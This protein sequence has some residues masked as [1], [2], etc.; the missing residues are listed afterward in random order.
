MQLARGA[1]GIS[2]SDLASDIGVSQPAVSMWEKGDRVP[3]DAALERLAAALQVLPSGLTDDRVATTT[4]MFR[5][6]GVK[7]K[8]DERR[9]EGNLEL[10]R[11][12]AARIM[13]NVELTPALPWPT[14]DDPL[15]LDVDEAAQQLRRVW[16]IPNGPVQSLIAYIEAAGAIVLRVAFGHPKVEAAYA[17]PRRDSQRWIS[18]NIEATDGARLR[19]TVAHELGHA[20]LHHWDAFNVPDERE[21]EAQAFNFA[22]ALL[23][24]ADEF[25]LDVIH[26][27]RRWDDFLRLRNKWGVSA[28]ALAR[29]AHNLGMVNQVAY[30]NLNIERRTRGHWTREPGDI[31]VEEPRVFSDTVEL[32]REQGGWTD[33]DFATAA[34]LPFDRL[35]ALLPEQFKNA[36]AELPRHGLRLIS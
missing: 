22:L 17:Q 14:S 29:R 7:T 36:P 8:R 19:L 11:L 20:V 13:E 12:A 21:R 5:A 3:E 25:T 27:N 32:I 33:A 26:T 35:A 10:A 6:A 9:V 15:S 4:P 18:L 34:G 24:P 31:A 28:A 1:L 30:R 16:R 2:Q 23:V